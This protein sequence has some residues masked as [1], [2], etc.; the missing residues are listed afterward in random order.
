MKKLKDSLPSFCDSDVINRNEWSSEI[1]SANKLAYLMHDHGFTVAVVIAERRSEA[2]DI[3]ADAGN[4]DRWEVSDEEASSDYENGYDDPRIE[5][6]GSNGKFFDIEGLTIV[7]FELPTV[8][9][10][11]CFEAHDYQ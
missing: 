2:L 7:S 3:A 10:V 4:L 5:S 1:G 9:F 6:L 8:S 11:A